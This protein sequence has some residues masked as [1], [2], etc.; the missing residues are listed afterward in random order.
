MRWTILALLALSACGNAQQ[1][2]VE[3][4]KA[5]TTIKLS[6][7]QGVLTLRGQQWKPAITIDASNATFTGIVLDGVTGVHIKGGTIVGPGGRSYGV[8]IVRA[9]DISVDTMTITGAHRGVTIDQSQDIAI[10]NNQL[11]GLISDGVDIARS[12]RILIDRNTCSKFTPQLATFDADGTKHDGDHPDCIQGWSVLGQPPTSDVTVT[13]NRADGI[14]QGVFFR[15][16]I[17]GGFDRLVIRN[18]DLHVGLSNAIAVDGAR[19]AVVRNNR[20]SAVI[21]AVHVRNGNQIKANI[22]IKD[23]VADVTCGNEV[24]DAPRNEA[25]RPCS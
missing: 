9:K 7:E 25:T 5:G 6:G 24:P 14:M 12:Q 17:N 19:G 1:A 11:T 13:N 4:A 10:K 2:K 15:G 23:S 8:R 3:H 18:N 20:V 22:I 16:T 21:G